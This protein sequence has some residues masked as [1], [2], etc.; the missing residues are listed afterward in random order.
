MWISFEFLDIPGR[1]RIKFSRSSRDWRF[2]NRPKSSGKSVRDMSLSPNTVKLLRW[3]KVSG[4]LKKRGGKLEI[5]K[6]K[7]IIKTSIQQHSWSS[8]LLKKAS[9]TSVLNGLT[10]SISLL[11]NWIWGEVCDLQRLKTLDIVRDGFDVW[12]RKRNHFRM[13]MCDKNETVIFGSGLLELG[14]VKRKWLSWKRYASLNFK[15]YT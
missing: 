3:T 14:P 10:Y 5:R 11:W 2:F 8:V 7:E 12:K 13:H 6:H 1:S 4:N 9:C 15:L